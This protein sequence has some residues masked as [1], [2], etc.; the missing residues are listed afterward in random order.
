MDT[1]L[2]TAYSRAP[3]GTA[4][5][6]KFKHSGIVLEIEKETHKIVNAE[7]TFITE[8]AKQFFSKLLVG[9]NFYEELDLIIKRINEHYYAPSQQSV[10][11]AL[12]IA[13][14]RYVDDVLTNN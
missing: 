12:K 4:M 13:H 14:Q 7:F 8:V 1:I 10:L 9:F 6:E 11:V 2:I 3:Q 5:Y